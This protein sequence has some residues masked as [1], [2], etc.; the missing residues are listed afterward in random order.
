MG[1][2]WLTVKNVKFQNYSGVRPGSNFSTMEASRR[3]IG[4]D[5]KPQRGELT[6]NKLN[7]KIEVSK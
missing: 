5:M 4:K 2:A 6:N 1:T 3:P 7:Q